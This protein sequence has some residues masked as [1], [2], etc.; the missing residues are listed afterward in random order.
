MRQKQNVNRVKEREGGK[1]RV[2]TEKEK[3]IIIS[4]VHK[5]SVHH[6]AGFIPMVEFS[7][8]VVLKS[9]GSEIQP[10]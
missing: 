7:N 5:F 1:E 10:F 6:S 2:K 4:V 8:Q 3:V 9:G